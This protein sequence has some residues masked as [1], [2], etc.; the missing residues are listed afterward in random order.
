MALKVVI[1]LTGT[2]AASGYTRARQERYDTK[3][4]VTRRDRDDAIFSAISTLYMLGGS[5]LQAYIEERIAL[6][7]Q[8]AV[9][10][11]EARK[12]E[13]D[14]EPTTQDSPRKP[15]ER[16]L[17]DEEEDDDDEDEGPEDDG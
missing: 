1:E 15:V 16:D 8:I 11:R 14:A 7:H 12:S 3:I 17:L 10:M 4:E 2:P 13:A 9:V 6:V 5:S